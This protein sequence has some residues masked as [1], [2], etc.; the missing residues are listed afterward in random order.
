[1]GELA[2][3][4]EADKERVA[5]LAARVAATKQALETASGKAG[6]LGANDIVARL[7]AVERELEE[8]ESG[9]A[10]LEGSLEKA[11]WQVMAAI[12]GIG[13]GAPAS[14]G[15]ER[16][17]E[18][19][20]D[21]LDAVPPHERFG[22]NPSGEELMG[23]NP[24]LSPFQKEHENAEADKGK[25]KAQRFGRAFVRNTGD[26]ADYVKKTNESVT[27]DLGDQFDP[28]GADSRSTVEVP[29]GQPSV[30][31]YRPEATDIK[32]SDVFGTTIVVAA[33]VVEGI[34]RFIR[35]KDDGR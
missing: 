26:A 15:G 10:V 19:H 34:S 29:T 20:P 16:L 30:H 27:F 35:K 23:Q 8:V 28:W 18:H 33:I 25:S 1:M 24:N 6:E 2:E 32:A 4:I 31:S 7:G 5:E 12:H 21:G 13:P 22:A 11:R 14:G 9:R 3:K 17:V